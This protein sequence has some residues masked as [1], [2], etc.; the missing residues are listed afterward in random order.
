MS[1]LRSIRLAALALVLA[2]VL[3]TAATKQVTDPSLPRSLSEGPV[4][5]SW[6][7]PAGFSEIRHS[8][9]PAEARRGT[10]VQDLATY[11]ATR[12]AARLAPGQTLEVAIQDIDL[13]GDYEPWHGPRMRDVRM[14]RDLYWPRMQLRYTLRDAGGQVVAEGERSL[15]EMGYLQGLRQAGRSQDPLR[16]EKE[17]LD[18]W[19]QQEFGQAGSLSAGR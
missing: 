16:Y 7:D 5:V 10:W 8:G 11:L 9:N 6:E 13:A 17:M 3:A 1:S 19:L 12:A 18:R 15:S 14:L 2:P 4:T